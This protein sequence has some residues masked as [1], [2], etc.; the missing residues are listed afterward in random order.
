[1]PIGAGSA[2]RLRAVLGGAAA[3]LTLLACGGK[4]IDTSPAPSG[5]GPDCGQARL[6]S[7]VLDTTRQ[8]YLFP[9]C[10]PRILIRPRSPRSTIS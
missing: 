9:S 1:M 2:A 4:G 5:G 8:W 10:C 3:T 6:K 7:A